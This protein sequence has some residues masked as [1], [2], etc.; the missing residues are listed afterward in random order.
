MTCVHLLFSDVTG[1]HKGYDC[2]QLTNAPLVYKL[3]ICMEPYLHIIG[4]YCLMAHSYNFIFLNQQI[5]F[6]S[7]CP[8]AKIC[9]ANIPLSNNHCV[10]IKYLL[11]VESCILSM[12][13]FWMI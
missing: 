12:E 8:A 2:Q 10:E 7:M 13:E 4:A 9:T 5:S 3:S 11:H 6:L 1:N